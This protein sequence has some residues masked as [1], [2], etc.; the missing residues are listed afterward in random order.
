MDNYLN[1]FNELDNYYNKFFLKNKINKDLDE[2]TEFCKNCKKNNNLIYDYKTYNKIC[3]ECGF[4]YENLVDETAEWRYYGHSDSKQNDPTRCGGNPT[5][6]L[7]PKSSM[8]TKIS[9]C[10]SKFNSIKRL[11]KWNQI[12]NDERSVYEVFKKIDYFLN[13][14]KNNINAKII[15]DAKL[16]YKLLCD[17]KDEKKILT[18]GKNRTSLIV[19]CLY[20]SAKNNNKPINEQKLLSTFQIE[21]T[22]LTKGIKKFATIEKQKN[23]QINSNK[24]NIHDLIESYSNQFNLTKDLTKLIHLI[25]IRCYIMN[26]IKNCNEKSIC[27]GLFYFIFCIF[28]IKISK[29]NIISKINVSEV[30]LNK[31]YNIMYKYKDIIIIGFEKI[32][33]IK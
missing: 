2:K 31:I 29:E 20:I 27:S 18:R 11:Q 33:F 12:S 21:K 26:I 9:N 6:I 30:T 19:A 13:T 4:I 16:Y 7:L 10:S 28:N 17:K 24:K 23:I 15:N 5:N 1:K 8:G 32:N 22:D 3:S 14:T 25:Y